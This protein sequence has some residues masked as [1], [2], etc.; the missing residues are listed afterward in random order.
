MDSSAECWYT[1]VD[2]KTN[3]V[4]A[5]QLYPLDLHFWDGVNDMITL[6]K[7][8]FYRKGREVKDANKVYER[9]SEWMGVVECTRK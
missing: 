4:S 9:F 2:K 5:S 6:S 1:K 3:N 7:W 8:K